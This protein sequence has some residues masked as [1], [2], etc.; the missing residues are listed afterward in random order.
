VKQFVGKSIKDVGTP[1]AV[2]DISK[3][4]SN[5]NRMLEACA[6][7]EFEWR[8]HIKTHKV[9]INQSLYIS[10]PAYAVYITSSWD[11]FFRIFPY[12]SLIT[13]CPLYFPSEY[14]YINQR[15]IN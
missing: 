12:T 4:E 10:Y 8:A 15:C 11:P 7:L 3:L 1:V 2:L 6:S 13:D 9:L 14:Q 5:C